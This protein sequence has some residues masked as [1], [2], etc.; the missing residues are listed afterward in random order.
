MDQGHLIGVFAIALL[1]IGGLT[2]DG[3]LTVENLRSIAR[4][5]APLGVLAVAASIALMSKNIDLSGIAVVGISAMAG[6]RLQTAHGLSELEAFL[7]VLVIAVVIGLINGWLVA[8]V[9]ISSLVATLGTWI[10]FEGLFNA[11]LLSGDIVFTLPQQAIVRQIGTGRLLGVDLVILVA[12]AVFVAAAFAMRHVTYGKLIKAAGDSPEAARFTGLPIRS[13]VIGVFVV[14]ALLAAVSG[15][16]YLGVSGSYSRAYAPGLDLMFNAITAAVIGGVSLSGGRGTI[17]GVLAGTAFISIFVN[18]MI[19]LDVSVVMSS[20]L[21]G[22]L[23]LAAL[24]ID[25]SLHP[26]DEET[27]RAGD[28]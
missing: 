2:I 28:L 14:V 20:V 7:A 11:T 25:S 10:L 17:L 8:F 26:R 16:L 9:G 15:A 19:L 21:R 4:L 13:I 27:S 6:V 1:L 5:A 24:A 18:L 23:L 3:V 22:G 12:A